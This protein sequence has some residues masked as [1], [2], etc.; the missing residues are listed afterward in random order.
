MPRLVPSSQK[1]IHLVSACACSWSCSECQAVFDMW[2]HH[3]PPTQEQIDQINRQFVV[4]CK[5]VHR[6]LF[7]VFGLAGGAL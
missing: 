1:S 5:R 2:P 4:H 3:A 6:D 7:P